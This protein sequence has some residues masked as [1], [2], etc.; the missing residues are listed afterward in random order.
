MSGKVE[1]VRSALVFVKK[2]VLTFSDKVVRACR[3]SLPDAIQ[4]SS[5]CTPR[6]EYEYDVTSFSHCTIDLYWFTVY[7]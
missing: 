5:L 3:L 7:N 4:S 6:Y 1:V 2:T